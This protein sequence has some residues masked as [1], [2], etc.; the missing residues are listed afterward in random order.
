MCSQCSTVV[1]LGGGG[2][3]MRAK[4]VLLARVNLGD[5]RF[6]FVEVAHKRR[7]AILPELL[8]GTYTGSYYLRFT[9]HGKRKVQPVGNDLDVAFTG[10]LNKEAD[11]E[12][13]R[14][15]LHPIY[16]VTTASKPTTERRTIAEGAAQYLASKQRAVASDKMRVNTVSLYSRIITDFCE[17]CGVTYFDE[18]TKDTLDAHLEWLR[19]HLKKRKN[20]GDPKNTYFNR[21]NLLKGF[22][23]MN[24]IKMKKSKNSGPHDPGLMDHD[25]FPMVVNKNDEE[26]AIGVLSFSKRDIAA[27][28]K[29]ADVD[30]C[31]LIQFALRTGF[32][33]NEIAHAEWADIDWDGSLRPFGEGHV[34]NICTRNK[35]PSQYLPHGFKTKNSK[36]RTV[37]I[38]TL[39]ERLASRRE[40]LASDSTLI[41][42]S[43]RRGTPD[44]NLVRHITNVQR[45]MKGHKI[46]GNKLGLHRF[47]KTYGT[48]VYQDNRDILLTSQLLG[49]SDPK[50]TLKYLGL[51]TKVSAQSAHTAFHGIGD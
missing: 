35:V 43:I 47:R 42:P 40:R 13:E 27:M 28:V 41:F 33:D 24:G 37:A 6:S 22:L 26:R 29:V 19:T 17:N 50:I 7:K 34:P 15:G 45:R 46:A 32:R 10:F 4:V 18:I 21:F 1:L 49:H 20:G 44:G 36:P 38:P 16:G 8:T 3:H 2:E 31:D 30:E 14:E 5:G 51:D 39:I 11:L 48:L 9:E 12:R 23:R 25:D